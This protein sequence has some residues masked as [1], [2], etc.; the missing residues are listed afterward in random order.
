MNIR[1]IYLAIRKRVLLLIRGRYFVVEKKGVK[2]LLDIYDYIDRMIEAYS[3]Y[4]KDQL[5]YFLEKL[6]IFKPSLFIDAGANSG[7]Y[8][9]NVGRVF[10]G[11]K[12]VAF[13]PDARNRSKLYAN[14]YLNGLED[15]TIVQDCALSDQSGFAQFDRYDREN[16]GRSMLSV[17]GA[18]SISVKP[19]DD[20]ISTAGERIAMKIDVEG[21][22]LSLLKGARRVL[23]DNFCFIQIESFEPVE[24][25]EYLGGLGYIMRNK[26]GNDYY[27]SR[28]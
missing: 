18:Y 1:S 24:V 14:L 20:L 25:F 21:H 28:D 12:I 9:I 3:V 22:E 13:E 7:L 4:E 8:T 27:F 2:Y 19:L 23:Q 11:I 6:S 17:D 26:F 16:S 5:A 15:A 10:P